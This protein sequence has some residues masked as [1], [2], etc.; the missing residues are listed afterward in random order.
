MRPAG[1]PAFLIDDG[2]KVDLAALA[3]ETAA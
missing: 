1:A 2:I 3:T